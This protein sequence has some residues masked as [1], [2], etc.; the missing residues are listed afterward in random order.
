MTAPAPLGFDQ[1]Q[2]SPMPMP[3]DPRQRDMLQAMGI[4][5]WEPAFIEPK[6]PIAQGNAVLAAINN[7]VSSGTPA[8]A[9]AAPQAPSQRAPQAMVRAAAVLPAPPP[10]LAGISPATALAGLPPG[11]AQMDWWALQSAVQSCQACGLCAGR[12]N[13]VFGTGQPSPQPSPEPSLDPVVVPATLHGVLPS[14]VP[15]ADWLIIGDAPD[16]SE[17]QHSAPFV[18]P[19][20]L[21]L[22]NMLRAMVVNGQ[23]LARHSNVFMSNVVK[24]RP[25]DNRSPSAQEIS[26][27]QPY[28]QRQIALLQPKI[29]LAMGRFAVQSLLGSTEPLGKLRGRV[30]YA[31]QVGA[32][33][34]PTPTP[35]P[36]PVPVPV[37]V[38][39]H[40]SYL[41]RNLPDKAK[42]WADLLLAMQTLQAASAA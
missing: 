6:Q 3:L 41:L 31:V 28:L 24:C 23:P 7:V 15:R 14:A 8:E 26:T 10:P 19:A 2:T 20:G 29:I 37:I 36:I 5:L 25:P 17:D 22:D 40:P 35:V 27:C 13:T 39:Y 38:T 16:E 11:I 18:G 33:P 42:A 32:A 21:L 12:K 9:H 30:H 1:S 34:A 4:T